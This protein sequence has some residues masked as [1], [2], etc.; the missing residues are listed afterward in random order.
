MLKTEIDLS[1]PEKVLGDLL[2]LYD[3][4]VIQDVLDVAGKK[5]AEF[6]MQLVKSEYPPPQRKKSM[7]PPMLRTAKQKRWWWYW[8]NQIA[9]GNTPPD[10]LLGWKASY[11][12]VDGR[13]V[14]WIDAQSG[15]KRT[16]TLVRGITYTVDVN[17][18]ALEI[19]VG[20]GLASIMD[21]RDVESYARY[22]IDVP[23]PDGQQARYHQNNWK[24]LVEI[25]NDNADEI[26]SYLGN[27]L[28]NEI[29][30]R[31]SQKTGGMT[32]Q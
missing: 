2:L 23:P 28:F 10:N 5:T 30:K 11:K 15:Y 32:F 12:R 17:D 1:V 18:D 21:D 3:T 19:Q 13:K 25:V 26:M 9:E 6:I 4:A 20:T 7:N 14:L 24:P 31:V 22:V 8:M 27:A 16:G 29:N